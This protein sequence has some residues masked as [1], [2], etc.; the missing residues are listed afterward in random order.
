MGA[1]LILAINTWLW[2]SLLLIAGDGSISEEDLTLILRQLAG[3]GLSDTEVGNLVRR[4]FAAAGASTERGMTFAEYR[5]A[6]GATHV[7]LQVD[8]PA[9]D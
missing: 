7:A 2:A 8:I 4:V 3:S 1:W 6:L 9:E 5:E